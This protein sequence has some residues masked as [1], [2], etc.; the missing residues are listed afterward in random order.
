MEEMGDY[1]GLGMGQGDLMVL[2]MFCNMTEAEGSGT[3]S[4]GNTVQN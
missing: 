1:Q 3:Y 4:C 2:G